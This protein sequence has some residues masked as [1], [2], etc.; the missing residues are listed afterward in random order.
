[1][2]F[3]RFAVFKLDNNTYR[4]AHTFVVPRRLSMVKYSKCWVNRNSIQTDTQAFQ[5]QDQRQIQEL[6]MIILLSQPPFF[7]A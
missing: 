3:I 5:L 2:V 1:M 4:I 6:E 7:S